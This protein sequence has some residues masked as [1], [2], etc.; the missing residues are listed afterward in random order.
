MRQHPLVLFMILYERSIDIM[1]WKKTQKPNPE[2]KSYD[3]D[4][5]E[6]EVNDAIKTVMDF[7]PNDDYE[8]FEPY[9][10]R[11]IKEINDELTRKGIPSI[12][13]P[14]EATIGD[15]I[16]L[17][18][19]AYDLTQHLGPTTPI[20]PITT[21][22]AMSVAAYIPIAPIAP[23][24]F[25]TGMVNPTYCYSGMINVSSFT[26]PEKYGESEVEEWRKRD[27]EAAK[28]SKRQKTASS[29]STNKKI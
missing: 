15:L 13:H 8:L 28:L 10:E 29:R 16:K 26:Y 27:L 25:S 14:G 23:T 19:K 6:W 9:L 24:I 20:T 12:Q 22:G 2:S 17:V 4:L 7:V 1:F 11:I 5:I 3:H 18:E 21:Y